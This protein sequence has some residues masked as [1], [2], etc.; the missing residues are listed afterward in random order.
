M[1]THTKHFAR[2]LIVAAIAAVTINTAFADDLNPPPYRG[3]PLSVYAHWNQIPGTTILDLTSWNS[4]DDTDPATY[5]YPNFTPN[6]Q[7]I[8]TNGVY[9]F[10]IPNWVDD[11]P[12]KYLRL[13]LT[14]QNNLLPPLNIFSQGLDGVNPLVG[15][16]VYTSPLQIDA[17]ALKAY[18]YYD[19]IYKPNPDFERIH[20]DMLPDSVLTQV[21]V[22]SISTVPEP[23]T[24]LLLAL[25]GLGLLSKRK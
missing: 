21:V 2:V 10:Q 8:P 22:D 19:L 12:I 16:I 18:Q 7:V 25:G 15:Q 17:A 11:L 13:Q 5:L 3:G 6:I 1:K 20:I 23:A 9:D 14:W 4:V 24:L